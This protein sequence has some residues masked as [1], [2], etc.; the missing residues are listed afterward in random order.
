MP[1]VLVQSKVAALSSVTLDSPPTAGNLLIATIMKRGGGPTMTTPAGWTLSPAGIC[2]LSADSRTLGIFYKESDGTETGIVGEGTGGAAAALAEFSGVLVAALDSDNR[3]DAW[4]SDWRTNL[5][6]PQGSEAE[7]LFFGGIIGDT[8]SG[9][10][11]T[12]DADVIELMDI[13]VTGGEKPASVAAYKIVPAIAPNEDIGGTGP[14]CQW[15]ASGIVF[16]E[17]EV[18]VPGGGGAIRL[19]NSPDATP[20]RLT[21]DPTAIAISPTHD[22]AASEGRLT[23]DPA[24]TPARISREGY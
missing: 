10:S 22:P 4:S 23:H 21:H 13:S 24:A 3:L 12:P 18:F 11:F 6:D 14:A 20:Y 9:G 7:C 2:V 5:L 16:E 19:T 15:S 1:I 17:K 8:F